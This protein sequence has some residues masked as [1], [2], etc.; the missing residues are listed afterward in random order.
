MRVI[1]LG[2][3]SLLVLGLL[4]TSIGF[5]FPSTVLVSRAID[6]KSYKQPVY[7][8]VSDLRN[9]KPWLEGMDN[10][11]VIVYDSISAKLGNTSVNITS[12][13]DTTVV[14]IWKNSSS[15]D[16]VSTIRLISDSSK[17]NTIVQWQFVQEVKWYPWEKF[18][19]LFIEKVTGASY[20]YGLA[21]LNKLANFGLS[22]SINSTRR[23]LNKAE[24]FRKNRS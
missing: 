24:T 19:G 22:S 1:K 14:S 2:L 11:N 10:P 3:I 8:L 13:T 23:R 15:A 20:E 6:I 9:W 7:I 18:S 16:Q 12:L 4:A 5:L 17:K 21:N